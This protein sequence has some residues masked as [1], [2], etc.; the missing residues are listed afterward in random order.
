MKYVLATLAGTRAHGVQ[1]RSYRF[2]ETYS[3][4]EKELRVCRL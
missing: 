4:T 2:A 3:I 1:I